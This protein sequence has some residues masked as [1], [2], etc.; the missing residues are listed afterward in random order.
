MTTTDIKHQ[1]AQKLDL[2]SPGLLTAVNEFLGSL[3][4]ESQQASATVGTEIE[5]KKNFD[6][7]PLIGLIDGSPGLARNAEDILQQEIVSGSGWTCK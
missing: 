2:L 7:D 6:D 4:A 5:M 3:L 1:I